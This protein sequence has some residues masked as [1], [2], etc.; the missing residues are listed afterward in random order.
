MFDLNFT[1][2]SL[3][4]S[5]VILQSLGSSSKQMKG[6]KKLASATATLKRKLE[7]VYEQKKDDR[8]PN[9]IGM[10]FSL[11]HFHDLCSEGSSV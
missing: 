5:P 4:E 2:S 3:C 8:R 6:Q 10:K 11:L 1:L 9:A 7:T